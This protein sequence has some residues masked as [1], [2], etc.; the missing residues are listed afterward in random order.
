MLSLEAF[1]ARV[2]GGSQLC[3]VHISKTAGSTFVE[4]FRRAAPDWATFWYSTG[5]REEFQ[6]AGAL[7]AEREARLCGGHF[8]VHDFLERCADDAVLLSFV[9]H[10]VGSRER[11]LQEL[12]AVSQPCR[13]VRDQRAL[14]ARFRQHPP[15]RGQ[16][17]RDPEIP[18]GLLLHQNP[19]SGG[20]RAQARHD[21]LAEG[22]S[23]FRE[24]P[25]GTDAKGLP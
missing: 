6:A 17:G 13:L 8:G 11:L 14:M 10:P 20:D 22:D 4:H 2:R 16:A 9:R 3:F 19:A 7:D 5:Q 12:S 23:R 24:T 18:H 15:A 1:E 25:R 21:L